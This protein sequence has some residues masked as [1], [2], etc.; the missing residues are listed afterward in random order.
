[1]KG[2]RSIG[3]G[4]GDDQHQVFVNNLY[5]RL[6]TIKEESRMTECHDMSSSPMEDTA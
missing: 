6:A 4:E 1:M 5:N 3:R 2:I